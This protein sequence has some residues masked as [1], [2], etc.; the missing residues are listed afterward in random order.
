MPIHEISSYR[1]EYTNKHE[2]FVRD[3]RSY[4]PFVGRIECRTEASRDQLIIGVVPDDERLPGNYTS[5]GTT[6]VGWTWIHKSDLGT[7]LDLLR[8]EKPIYMSV[9][10]H[11]Y[12]PHNALRTSLEPVGESEDPTTA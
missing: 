1:L 7:F 8:N 9:N 5:P 11:P 2:S 3:G 10:P 6:I 4:G 12:G